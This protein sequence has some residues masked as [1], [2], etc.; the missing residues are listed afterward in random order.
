MLK[1]KNTTQ[2]FLFSLIITIILFVVSTAKSQS[3]VS[4][5]Q[6]EYLTFQYMQIQGVGELVTVDTEPYMTEF[7]SGGSNGRKYYLDI[8]GNDGWELIDL[9]NT[10]SSTYSVDMVFKRPKPQS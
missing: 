8:L 3:T 4:G 2:F 10:S 5:T 9:D 1:I 7:G 6:W